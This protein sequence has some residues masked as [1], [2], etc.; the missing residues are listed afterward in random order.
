MREIQ[1]F[2]GCQ[3]VGIRLQCGVDYP[4]YLHEGFPE[5]FILKENSLCAG[6]DGEALYTDDGDPLLACM[7]GLV[8]KGRCEARFPFFT[9]DGCFWTN[10]TS[11]LLEGAS[12]EE[13]RLLS[14]TK[15]ICHKSGYE[16]VSLVPVKVN[17]QI[18]G[19]IQLNDPQTGMFTLEKISLYKAIAD[20][21]GKIVQDATDISE[22][23]SGI[24]EMTRVFKSSVEGLRSAHSDV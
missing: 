19:L 8:V 17:G 9:E 4:Y 22:E 7:C 5:F 6:G 11:K 14:R 21:V 10:S 2:S 16:S 1:T 12:R 3:S 15:A 24:R 18:L 13:Q 20:K 23:V